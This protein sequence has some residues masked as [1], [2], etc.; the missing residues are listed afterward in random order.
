MQRRTVAFAV[1]LGTAAAVVGAGVAV[2]GAGL[3]GDDSD[4][5]QNLV[6]DGTLTQEQADKVGQAL[7]EHHEQR[8]AERE[9]EHEARHAERNQLIADTIGISTDE[10]TQRLADGETLGEI[11]GDKREE[12]AA[13]LVDQMV[14][15]AQSR[16]G[17]DMTEEQ[18]AEFRTRAEERVNAMLDGEGPGLG[19]HAGG[20]HGPGGLGGPHGPGGL[21]GPHGGGPLSDND[22]TDSD[23]SST[24]STAGV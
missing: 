11:A 5:L 17:E 9:A 21:G 1:A 13:V 4:V 14:E 7:E 20:P 6:Q 15:Q 2:A 10:L 22:A 24:T 3:A 23:G 18:L 8:A 19:R 12:L 16:S